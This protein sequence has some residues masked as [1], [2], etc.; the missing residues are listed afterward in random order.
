MREDTTYVEVF[1]GVNP[2]DI[3]YILCVYSQTMHSGVQ[4]DVSGHLNILGF[5][6]LCIVQ[7]NYGLNKTPAFQFLSTIRRGVAEYQYLSGYA[8]FPQCDTLVNSCNGKGCHSG[9]F[10]NSGGLQ[11]SVSVCLRLN[12]RHKPAARRHCTLKCSSIVSEII[13]IDFK[14]RS[15]RFIGSDGRFVQPFRYSGGENSD[16][17]RTNAYR[18]K[19]THAVFDKKLLHVKQPC[20]KPHSNYYQWVNNINNKRYQT[21]P[22]HSLPTERA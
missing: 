7:V 9:S 2:L 8:V 11:C 4:L 22:C 18:N 12:H 19:M 13:R 5:Q 10:K 16:N 6:H 20:R 17:P 3:L 21:K 14:P 15:A 1:H